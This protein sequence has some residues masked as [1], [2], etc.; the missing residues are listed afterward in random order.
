VSRPTAKRAPRHVAKAAYFFL[1]AFFVAF[2]ATFFLA[3]F[4][5][6]TFLTA[7]FGAAFFTLF[8]L[9]TV[10]PPLN[11]IY[12]ELRL[13]ASVCLKPTSQ[14]P[15]TTRKPRSVCLDLVRITIV[16]IVVQQ[17]IHVWLSI[18]TK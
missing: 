10:R 13:A 15:P 11:R 16:S 18:L 14:V 17:E 6:A 3:T 1:R 9:A 12:G 5:L 8:F 2:L 7:F 4:F